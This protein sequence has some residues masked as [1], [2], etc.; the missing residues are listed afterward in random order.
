MIP[1]SQAETAAL[2]RRLAGD[3]APIETHISL[4][5]LGD[6][7][8]WKLRKA[9][10]LPFLDFSTL[11]ERHRTAWREFELNAPHAPGMYRDVVP[12]TRAPDGSLAVDG[13]GEPVDWVVRMAR[14]P[15]GDFLDV[16]AERG[17]L[18][19]GLLDALGDAVAAYLAAAP[20]VAADGFATQQWMTDGDVRSA[21]AAGLPEA[22]VARWEAAMRRDLARRAGWLR[23]RAAAGF[24][25]RCHGDLH[26]GNIC[27]WRGAPAPFDAVEFDE[28]IA[29]GDVAY[30]L[31]FLLMDLEHKAGR[32]AAN[33]V[34]NRYVARSGDA[35]LVAGL[36][37]F[38][39]QK[40]MIRAHVE[41][42]R[43]NGAE[44]RAYLAMSLGYLH[45][46]PPVVVAIGGLQG[47]GKSTLARLLA[48]DLGPAP[49][50]LV[51]RS[52]EIRKRRHGV[53]P[54]QHLPEAAYSDAENHAVS[55]ELLRAVAEVAASGHAAVG[56][57]MFID[58]LARRGIA[59]AA[60]R[61]PFVGIWLEAPVPVLEARIARRAHDA[62]DATVAVLHRTLRADPGP[63]AWHVV[64]ATDLE[65]AAA[66]V[67]ALV[68]DADT[69]GACYAENS[70][71]CEGEP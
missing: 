67:R 13:G 40:A 26:L 53:A 11:A 34:L 35:A 15:A 41:A 17:A 7:T 36:P 42:A 1:P 25:R 31:A 68:R 50:A 18:D 33:R 6:D 49:G 38:M 39:A 57:T 3:R 10:T 63:M 59:E 48:P 51:L 9:V 47:T 19:D 8:V 2:L 60:G 5:F 14:V 54:E 65:R 28:A 43:G 30:D 21:R 46:P 62:S 71:P 52:D 29:T 32:A 61:V 20:T 56:D 58:P 23:A 66:S 64:D 44:A 69:A 37:L 22:D 45:P 16:M 24:V 27:L 4:A 55:G 12:I 70:N